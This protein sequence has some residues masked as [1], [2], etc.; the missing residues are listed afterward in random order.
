MNFL[1]QYEQR[2]QDHLAGEK[3]RLGPESVGI[4]LTNACNLNCITCWSYS[5]LLNV[6]PAKAWKNLQLPLDTSLNLIRE[7]ASLGTKR[8][9]LTGGGDPLVYPY[10]YETVELAKQLKLKVTLISNLTLIKDFERFLNLKIDTIQANFSAVDAQSYVEFHPNRKLI[11]FEKLI[12]KLSILSTQTPDLKLVCVV[13]KT[14]F[15][16]IPQLIKLAARLKAKIQFKLMSI[17]DDTSKVAINETQRIYLLQ[18]EKNILLLASQLEVSS[19]LHVFF[20][21]LKGEDVYSFPID[22]IGCFAG[23]W[24]SRVHA[25]GMV[26]YCCNPNKELEMGS[27]YENSFSEIWNSEDYLAMRKKLK[28]NNF[29]NGCQRCGKFDLNFKIKELIGENNFAGANRQSL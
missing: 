15:D 10:F 4:V 13:C 20:K 2:L 28:G 6:K 3:P 7:L 21:T 18:Q 29:V 5:P 16:S 24:Y 19:N 9:I 17:T 12:S 27:L 8:I 23:N 25:D 22:D 14:N 26:R 1:Q 11:D